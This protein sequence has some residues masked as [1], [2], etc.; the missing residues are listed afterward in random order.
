MT[1]AAGTALGFVGGLG[2][3]EIL[4]LLIVI[5]IPVG[6]VLLLRSMIRGSQKS[7]GVQKAARERL[8]ELDLLRSSNSITDSEY[9]EKRQQ[10]LD[11]I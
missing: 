1:S 10:I 7:Y 9:A 3:P 4:V 2:G 11:E 6:I 5:G 8:A